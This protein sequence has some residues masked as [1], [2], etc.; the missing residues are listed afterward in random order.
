MGEP[1]RSRLG[2]GVA[3]RILKRVRDDDP[4]HLVVQRSASR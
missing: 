4:R 3:E 2:A 1:D